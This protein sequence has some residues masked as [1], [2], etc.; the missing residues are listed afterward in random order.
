MLSLVCVI[1]GIALQLALEFPR[2]IVKIFLPFY[3]QLRKQI[4]STSSGTSVFLSLSKVEN[5]CVCSLSDDWES[6]IKWTFII[7]FIFEAAS[8]GVIVSTT[9]SERQL[10]IYGPL[11]YFVLPDIFSTKVAISVISTFFRFFF[12][13]PKFLQELSEL[14][15]PSFASYPITLKHFMY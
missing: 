6:L 7:S 11:C 3:N 1:T 5:I 10:K 14:L 13:F 12:F 2:H 15:L 4:R 9:Q 8:G